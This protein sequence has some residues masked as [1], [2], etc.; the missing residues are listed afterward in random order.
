MTIGPRGS[1]KYC[2]GDVELILWISTLIG[3]RVDLTDLA[4]PPERERLEPGRGV[5]YACKQREGG[6]EKRES[7]FE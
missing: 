4:F 5:L 3:Y 7:V 2:P 1:T 6:G